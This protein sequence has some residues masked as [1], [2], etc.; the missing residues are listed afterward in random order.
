VVLAKRRAR[1]IPRQAEPKDSRCVFLR[2][3]HQLPSTSTTGQYPRR[4][5]RED[6]QSALS[7]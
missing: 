6:F 4:R 2:E 7:L 5:F 1:A 3:R